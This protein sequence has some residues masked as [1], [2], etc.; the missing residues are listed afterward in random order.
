MVLFMVKKRLI[1]IG[2]LILTVSQQISFA[3]EWNFVSLKERGIDNSF[4]CYMDSRKITDT[5]SK[6]FDFLKQV[7]PKNY[8]ILNKDNH[9]IVAVDKRYGKIGDELE[10]HF[11][12]GTKIQVYIGD[13]KKSQETIGWGIHPINS[14]KG[15]QVEFLVHEDKIPNSVR[16]TGD[17]S[18][19]IHR[20]SGGIKTIK[21]K[22]I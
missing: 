21:N 2:I 13:Y 17:F 22:S 18:T 20:Y 7:F 11:F 16:K 5:T 1:G 15:C 19:Y 14:Q 10:I 3:N 12:N 9:Y 8:G 4:L 6:Q